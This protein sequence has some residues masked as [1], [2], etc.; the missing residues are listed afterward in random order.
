MN[1]KSK[2]TG[3]ELATYLDL[4]REEFDGNGDAFCL[5]AGYGV[6]S[7]DGVQ[8]CDFPGFVR[9]LAEAVDLKDTDLGL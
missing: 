8:K 5:A 6:E 7:L 4:H 9:A 2:L 1:K 3:K